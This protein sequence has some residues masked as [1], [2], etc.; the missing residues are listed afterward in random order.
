MRAIEKHP[1]KDIDPGLVALVLEIGGL[2]ADVAQLKVTISSAA[3]ATCDA[4]RSRC[5]RG[6][7]TATS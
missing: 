3:Q 2:E 7:D 6:S 1:K 5:P 4:L